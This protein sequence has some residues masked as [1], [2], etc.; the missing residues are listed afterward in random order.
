MRRG[1]HCAVGHGARPISPPIVS[2]VRVT[3]ILAYVI[4]H[5]SVQSSRQTSHALLSL[6]PNSRQSG[7]R[8]K[9]CHSRSFLLTGPANGQ[10]STRLCIGGGSECCLFYPAPLAVCLCPSRR[11]Q[12]ILTARLTSVARAVEASTTDRMETPK[13]TFIY[14]NNHI[15][16]SLNPTLL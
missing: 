14:F 13:S 3:S 12:S 9:A 11:I 2:T 15:C 8:G 6:R 5:Q 7:F 1:C 10:T 4:S 16:T